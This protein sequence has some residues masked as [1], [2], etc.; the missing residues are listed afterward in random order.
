MS[1]KVCECCGQALP[2]PYA[3]IAQRCG[4]S[5]SQTTLFLAVAARNGQL[6][7]HGHL[8]H[9]LWGHDP[10]GGP[11]RPE[12]VVRAFVHHCNRRLAGTGLGV[13]GVWGQGYRLTRQPVS[14]SQAV[15]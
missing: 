6:V 5:P 14:L 15:A 4:L 8:Y 3:A 1:A 7:A 12:N 10:N 2:E 13:M 9:L 11:D